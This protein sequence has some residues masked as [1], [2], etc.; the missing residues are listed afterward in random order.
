MSGLVTTTNVD[1][2]LPEIVREH[3]AAKDHLH[4]AVASAIRAGELLIQAKALV[5]RGE[6][7][8]GLQIIVRSPRRPL[9]RTCGLQDCQRK[10]ATPLRV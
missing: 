9:K 8:I 2:L 4:Q 3:R 6:R 10:T 7:K 1:D 5:K